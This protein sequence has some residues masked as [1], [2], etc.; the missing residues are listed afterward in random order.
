MISG[1]NLTNLNASNLTTGNL[2]DN[3]LSSNVTLTG[4]IFNSANHLVQLTAGGLLPALS[5]GNL[6]NLSATNLSIGTIADAR[7]SGNVT[8]LGN[9][10]NGA[11]GLAPETYTDPLTGNPISL[12]E[13]GLPVVCWP[14]RF[15]PKSAKFVA[16][17][18]KKRPQS[19]RNLY[20][21]RLA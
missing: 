3:L 9:T 15:N 17:K 5:G 18:C 14:A 1:A 7:L 10:F 13:G 6:T 8:V 19:L 16:G 21:F 4:N 2:N 12:T 20:N 11:V